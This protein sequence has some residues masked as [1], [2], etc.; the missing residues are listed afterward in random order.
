M[1]YEEIR[2]K[3]QDLSYISVCSLSILYN[4]KFI[5]MAILGTNAIIVTR[6]HYTE[7]LTTQIYLQLLILMDILHARS[8]L[9]HH[10]VLVF[11]SFALSGVVFLFGVS[12]NMH[13]YFKRVLKSLGIEITTMSETVKCGYNVIYNW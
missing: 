3:K 13:C 8:V 10:K 6:V 1:F 11:V 5:L 4:S 9:H 7:E 12:Y 2:K